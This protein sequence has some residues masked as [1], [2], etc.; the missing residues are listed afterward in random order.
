MPELPGECFV[1][2]QRAR[3]GCVGLLDNLAVLDH[4]RVRA[5]VEAGGMGSLKQCA[6]P[7]NLAFPFGHKGRHGVSPALL[8]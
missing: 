4:K 7:P 8:R 2:L 1:Q 3:Q 6:Q 5:H